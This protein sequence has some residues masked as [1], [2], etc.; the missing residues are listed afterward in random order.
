[1]AK[2]YNINWVSAKEDYLTN[3]FS[4][5]EIARK[6]GCSE[7]AIRKRAKRDGWIREYSSN[8]GSSKK[9]IISNKSLDVL[10]KA[11]FVYIIYLD[12][13]ADKR[14][15]KIGMSSSFNHRLDSHKSS[16]P[17]D[18]CVACAYYVGN[19]RDEEHVLHVLFKDKRVRGE[20]FNLNEEDLKLIS[21]RSLLV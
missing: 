20:W 16:S 18:L 13:S 3:S 5:R 10:D 9:V 21:S 6:H 12:D 17:F 15:Y 2:D 1:M 14:Y 11:G 4:L 7:A 8:E 19:M